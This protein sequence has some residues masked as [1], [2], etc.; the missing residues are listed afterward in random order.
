MRILHYYWVDPQDPAGRGG[1]VRVYLQALVAA[2]NA[3]PGVETC[4]F[5]SGLAYDLRNKMPRWHS[6]RLGHYEIVNSATLAPSHADFATHAQLHDAPTTATFL[7]FVKCTG[8]YDVLHLHGLEGIPAEILASKQHFPEMRLVLSLHNYHAFCPQVNLWWQE[9]AHCADFDAGARCSTCLPT[10]ARPG[11]VRAAYRVE[12][13]LTRL[14]MGP[15]TLAYDRAWRVVIR[16]AWRLLKRLLRRG[17]VQ[18]NSPPSNELPKMATVFRERRAGIVRLINTY[19]DTVLAVSERTRQ[20]AEQFGLEGVRTSYIGTM[21]ARHWGM[22]SPRDL[23]RA[24]SAARPLRL[25]YLGYMRRDKGFGFLLDALSDLPPQHLT[26]VHL[27]IAAR[28]G[29]SDVIAA[30]TRLTP[31]LAGLDWHDGYD[32]GDLDQILAKTDFGLVPPLWEDNLP[33]TALEMHSRHIPLITSDRGGAQELGNCP[34]LTFA[35]GDK[36]AFCALIVR[37]L[38]GAVPMTEY[39]THARAPIS[40]ADHVQDLL[41]QY[42]GSS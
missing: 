1:G 33:Q 23:P 2:Q 31:T 12:T 32:H 29:D 27:C 30:M 20:I 42:A 19:C 26:R 40:M 41:K 21:H 35:A 34:A 36:A 7:E 28:R 39:W 17:K 10:P 38:E 14:S 11:V 16:F 13:V 3:V 18:A 24:Y 37:V 15:G 6:S 25:T 5:S 8:P 9:Q 4:T 22:T